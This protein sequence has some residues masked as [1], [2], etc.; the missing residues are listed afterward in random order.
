M[1]YECCA[2]ASFQCALPLAGVF[3]RG[4]RWVGETTLLTLDQAGDTSGSYQVVC[5]LTPRPRVAAKLLLKNQIWKIKWENIKNTQKC[6]RFRGHG[7]K[8]VENTPKIF[9]VR[10]R[11]G[12][13]LHERFL[14]RALANWHSSYRSRELGVGSNVAP[15]PNLTLPAT[16]AHP[17]GTWP[18]NIFE[19]RVGIKMTN[20]TNTL[21]GHRQALGFRFLI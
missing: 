10:K 17:I 21:R 12:V 5:C 7:K 8:H 14:C 6:L 18:S 11:E 4:A 3:I 13:H 19:G 9:R 15:F 20:C 2:C 16:L 1:F